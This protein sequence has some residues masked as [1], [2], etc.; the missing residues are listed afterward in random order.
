MP[1]VARPVVLITGAS[2]G[3]GEALALEYSARG[4]DLALLARR[5]D[6]LASV[7]ERVKQTGARAITIT[8]DVTDHERLAS[9]FEQTLNAFGRIDTAIANSGLAITGR[10]Q[11]LTL[12]QYRRQFEVN[13]FALVDTAQLAIEPLKATRGRLVLLSS[14][15]G[16]VA[17]PG[18]SPYSMSKFAVRA[19]GDS[20]R[21]ELRQYGISVTTICPGFVES[22]I[23]KVGRDGVYR[24]DAHDPVPPWLIVPVRP[25]VKHMVRAIERRRPEVVVT[26]HG[27]LFVFLERHMPGLSRALAR[28]FTTQ[29]RDP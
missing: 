1:D 22:E 9:A 28:G 26:G 3:I 27:K 20:L 2:S 14:V 25:A 13:V 4:A 6:R 18:M 16:Y 24:A 7:A 12:E 19:F 15:A 23:R 5:A 11:K 21:G 29:V 17:A 8:C 10:V